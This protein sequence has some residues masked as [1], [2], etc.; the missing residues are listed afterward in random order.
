MLFY[1]FILASATL[2]SDLSLD[3]F[4]SPLPIS[5]SFTWH[6]SPI[7]LNSNHVDKFEQLNLFFYL[8]GWIGELGQ[9]DFQM[10]VFGDK[11]FIRCEVIVVSEVENEFKAICNYSVNEPGIYGPVHIRLLKPETNQTLAENPTFGYFGVLS[12]EPS[13]TENSLQVEHIFGTNNTD[14]L[15][16]QSTSISFS[17]TLES[18]DYLRPGDYLK[19]TSGKN[20]EFIENSVKFKWTNEMSSSSVLKNT[21]ISLNPETNELFIY[22]FK[23]GWNL[24][25]LELNVSFEITGIKVP[26]SIISTDDNEW[27]LDIWRYGGRT[28]VKKFA[29]KGPAS[30]LVPGKI[31]IVS[32]RPL[33]EI[34]KDFIFQEYVGY[35][36]IEINTEHNI[37]A[38]GEISMELYNVSLC[39]YSFITDK[40][41]VAKTAPGLGDSET[42]TVV[43]VNGDKKEL[44]CWVEDFDV[45]SQVNCT[46]VEEIKSP[47]FI[48]FLTQF[49][50]LSLSV[51]STMVR[52]SEGN[53]VDALEETFNVS[54]T[55]I[56]QLEVNQLYIA[57]SSSSEDGRNMV[58]ESGLFGLVFS[59]NAPLAL[60]E[61]DMITIYLPAST[62]HTRNERY[63]SFTEDYYGLFASGSDI[64]FNPTILSDAE[65]IPSYSLFISKGQIRIFLHTKVESGSS[66]VYFI[67]A[68]DSSSQQNL[69]LPLIP[70]R[71]TDFSEVIVILEKS[72]NI[73]AYS[74]PLYLE[75][76]ID[77]LELSITSFC[78]NVHIGGLPIE[79][80]VSL[81]FDYKVSDLIIDFGFSNS[82]FN[83]DYLSVG[84]I[85]PTDNC[86][87]TII[88][89][90]T[91]RLETDSISK[92][93]PIDII[94]P[95][96]LISDNQEL[97]VVIKLIHENQEIV[98]YEKSATLNYQSDEI[99]YTINSEKTISLQ[100]IKSVIFKVE[101]NDYDSAS[102]ITETFRFV[103]IL[104]FGFNLVKTDLMLVGF[105]KLNFPFH[106]ALGTKEVSEKVDNFFIQDVSGPWFEI[107]ESSEIIFAA[108]LGEDFSNDNCL[109][110]FKEP[111]SSISPSKLTYKSF[112]PRK[113]AA[114]TVN[115]PLIELHLK[116]SY[117]G[118]I[119][120]DSFIRF[121]LSSDWSE[122]IEADKSWVSIGRELLFGN[123]SSDNIWTS[124]KISSSSSFAL[125][126][127][128]I[129]RL[130]VYDSASN[131]DPKQ[132]IGFKKVEIFSIQDSKEL[133]SFSW[134]QSQDDLNDMVYTEILP[135]DP[136]PLPS[137]ARFWTFPDVIGS[138]SVTFGASFN[139][140]L[141]LPAG[142][143]IEVSPVFSVDMS[144]SLNTWMNFECKSIEIND[145]SL[146]IRTKDLLIKGFQ[147]QVLKDKA[148]DLKKIGTVKVLIKVTSNGQTLID[149]ALAGQDAVKGFKVNSVPDVAVNLFEIA[150]SLV[151]SGLDNWYS[152]YLTLDGSVDG[153]VYFN[154]VF[155]R[156]FES[157]P[158]PTYSFED[159]PGLYFVEAELS[160]GDR[161]DCWTEHWMVS[162]YLDEMISMNKRVSFKVYLKNPLPKAT[163]SA[164][165]TNR[166]GEVIVQ[167][168]IGV[169]K[170]IGDYI[171]DFNGVIEISHFTLKGGK[172]NKGY[173]HDLEIFTQLNSIFNSESVIFTKFP[174]PYDLNPID[175]GSLKCK[176]Q[177]NYNSSDIILKSSSTCTVLNNLAQI[178]VE[179]SSGQ[180]VKVNTSYWTSISF[181][182]LITPPEGY[183]QDNSQVN[184][185]D[186]DFYS[187]NFLVGKGTSETKGKYIVSTINSVSLPN[188]TPG[189]IGFNSDD[190]ERIF[191]NDGKI[192]VINKGTFLG[193]IK[194]G[195]LTGD[196]RSRTL[197]LKA[198]AYQDAPIEFRNNGEVFIYNEQA[199]G[200]FW[201]GCPSDSAPGF[202]YITWGL[203]ET[204]FG[205][206]DLYLAPAPTLV[207][208]TE[209][210]KQR[211]VFTDDMVVT[212][213]SK[214]IPF[215]LS[216]ENSLISAYDY[217]QV[218]LS[219]EYSYINIVFD[220]DILEFKNQSRS[221]KFSISCLE[222][223]EG[224]TYYFQA[225]IS[226]SDSKAFE[227]SEYSSFIFKSLYNDSAKIEVKME[228]LTS[229]NV[230]F[231]L[232]SDST[233]LVT[234]CLAGEN[235]LHTVELSE[236]YVLARVSKYWSD[237]SNYPTF[238]EQ[239]EDYNNEMNDLLSNSSDYEEFST[240]GLD[241]ARKI[242]FSGQNMINEGETKQIASFEK[243]V[244]D[245]SYLFFI[246]VDNGLNSTIQKVEFKT[247]SIPS[248]AQVSLIG[249][250]S[251][252]TITNLIV[253]LL[254]IDKKRISFINYDRRRL[255]T[256]Q[257][258]I[259]LSSITLSKSGY[260]YIKDFTLEQLSSDLGS[261]VNSL[262][263]LSFETA[264]QGGWTEEPKWT[265]VDEGLSINFT[266]S[267]NG[268]AYCEIE[269]F[270]E[271]DTKNI[272][273]KQLMNF[274]DRYWLDNSENSVSFEV[275]ALV[276][277]ENFFNFSRYRAGDYEVSCTI[278]NSFPIT[279]KCSDVKSY[280]YEMEVST[281]SSGY[282]FISVLIYLIILSY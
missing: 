166:K 229:N 239:M 237:K 169:E 220:P 83:D 7:E 6:L 233:A 55:S 254:N 128:S 152:V 263:E 37:P 261:T 153:G 265:L 193:P 199:S 260:D 181:Q 125:D 205:D 139:L 133:R 22:G 154:F 142:S 52:D 165:I 59:F 163:V 262:T 144:A 147:V 5:H 121:E 26:E 84:D 209:D 122:L 219:H 258:F 245:T 187:S 231:Y 252:D 65:T 251:K 177:Y 10:K 188:L 137:E 119:H 118:T 136:S 86:E 277:D 76:N 82:I 170:Y 242:Y 85:Y 232:F 257:S 27:V 197:K 214:S 39:Q 171:S 47:V 134:D 192:I 107:E 194:V 230:K 20:F 123:F 38:G 243:L 218:S 253:N 114:F 21:E 117:E 36:L 202:Y 200:E 69:S 104:P 279:P 57:E 259:I 62:A 80:Q 95:L 213:Y 98:I 175:F 225:S 151:N 183:V 61:G 130:P 30:N 174:Y 106:I 131:S 73:F 92:K 256:T 268:I 215:T 159:L 179:L 24:K 99:D 176:S 228:N 238:D 235:L 240:K 196:V 41:Q 208:I 135:A 75:K 53:L 50:D 64:K 146:V 282:L 90:Y 14:L 138:K 18:E 216:F 77:D 149:D 116:L 221:E 247:D 2:L 155:S 167:P 162:C 17:F 222:C 212:P 189:F 109:Y 185:L 49:I 45:Y 203:S 113:S 3:D 223:T 15:V 97:K 51:N 93:N 172:D 182:G 160:S 204:H 19:L 115:S 264:E 206:S 276:S 44:S 60:D 101:A 190:Y 250:K 249:S 66:L 108:A 211:L 271:S 164:F 16:S 198:T 195:P 79:I 180:D 78:N 278:C 127:Y 244:P 67:A 143:I 110:A 191:V 266:S 56:F 91:L 132:V 74:Q 1:S 224:T 178:S 103:Y 157:H 100:E 88:D 241:F 29:G 71:L 156:D 81:S 234:W 43:A 68:G 207:E 112:S 158:G 145:N 4:L 58:G 35:S 72:S 236:E 23:D 63:L 161:M 12:P 129:L 42:C 120:E 267:V 48:Y 13:I 227:V 11:S 89:S 173:T 126:I 96:K 269:S 140:P 28:L 255:Q 40:E 273:S 270:N 25:R 34:M 248:H 201:L 124:Q 31:E 94:I 274:L 226:G 217:I 150:P 246:V 168:F 272:T 186:Y 102:A 54:L 184:S 210:T 46:T 87:L 281:S 148:F 70:T 105:D 32:W 111:Y 275:T 33:N 280:L 141:N 8:N 9:T